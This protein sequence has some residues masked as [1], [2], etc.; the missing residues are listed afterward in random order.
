MMLFIY[1][2]WLYTGCW[3]FEW[4]YLLQRTQWHTAVCHLWMLT[5]FQRPHVWNRWWCITTLHDLSIILSK[6]IWPSSN[7]KQKINHGYGWRQICHYPITIFLIL[8]HHCRVININLNG[9]MNLCCY[10]LWGLIVYSVLF[11]AH[12]WFHY[13]ASR[14]VFT[15]NRKMAAGSLFLRIGSR[16]INDQYLI[17]VV[18]ALCLQQGQ[19]TWIFKW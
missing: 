18:F 16:L 12:L 17:L 19:R 4:R 3:M 2:S 1:Y 9:K 6:F 14:Q 13:G 5:R 11:S 10:F 7:T 15:I 8:F